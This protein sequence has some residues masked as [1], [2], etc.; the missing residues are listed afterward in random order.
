MTS[1]YPYGNAETVRL[2]VGQAVVRFLA[3][4]WS[5]RDGVEQRL[6]AGCF[7]IFGHGNVAGIGQALLQNDV[8]VDADPSTP[9]LPY[10]LARN[11]QGA[12]HAAAGYAKTTNRLQTL[13]VTTSIGPGALNMVTGAALATTNRLPVLLFPSDQFATRYPDPVLQQLEDPRSLD[14][15]VNDAFKPVSRFWDRI[16]RPEQL[17]P[18][19]IAAMR[20][21]TDPAETGAVTICLPQDV[22]AEAFDW[23]VELFAKRVW[24][25]AR[26]V[27]EPVA[28]RRVVDAIKAA[29]RPLIVAGGGVIYSGAS[30]ALR[31][32]A[33]A[34]GIPVA[35]T[36]AGK[37]AINWDHPLAVGGVGSTGNSAANTLAAEADLVIGI[38]TRYSDFTTASHTVFAAPDVAFANI[39]VLAFDAAKHSAT[40]LVADAREALEA[41]RG[42]LAG[43]STDEGYQQRA[44]QLWD[45]WNA[46]IDECFH[47]DNQ[48]LPA[49]TEV[50]GALNELMGDQD[51]VIN[52]AGSM[53][54]DLQALWRARTPEQY[55]LEYAFSCMGYEI[56][57]AM[58]VRMALDAEGHADR[59]VVA[60]VGD[61]TYQMLP[62]ELATI[63]SEGL[64]VIIVLL[65]NHGY[66]SIGALS[67]SRGSQRFGTRYRMRDAES[68]R[69]DGELV[70]F[71]LAANAASWGADVLRCN[72]IEEFRD[73]YAKAAA[74]PRAT[75][76]YIETNLYGP[77]PPG[78]A[79]WDV[80]VSEA[81][82]LESTQQAFEEYATEKRGQRHYL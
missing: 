60:I 8:D 58:G 49:Q 32:F 59:Q 41:L 30:A 71:D 57:A 34:T 76:L 20:V 7:G 24:H 63:V 3:N 31:E 52:A 26:P 45:E 64:K 5:E 2:T 1:T 40:M 37:G 14:V 68:G 54:G 10:F 33:T 38:G 50:F 80:P 19:L 75:V 29:K 78:C 12:V 72:G 21:L 22:Q 48:P 16:N 74:S 4:Q 79:W 9:D 18:S 27:P 82:T 35:D 46:V 81:S 53:P 13:A 43:W 56:P 65:Q 73:N 77:N 51:V 39:N 66:A 17:I 61:G 23:P 67:E 36:Q 55:H 6:I 42:E 69:L 25:V 11:E 47:R 28:L 62:M 70:P 44:G 15:S